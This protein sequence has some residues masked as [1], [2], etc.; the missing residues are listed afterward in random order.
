MAAT[1]ESS[2][3]EDY[4]TRLKAFTQTDAEKNDMIKVSCTQAFY[5]QGV[6]R[7]LIFTIGTH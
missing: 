5:P 7:S 1:S 4:S 3:L 2:Q 6:V